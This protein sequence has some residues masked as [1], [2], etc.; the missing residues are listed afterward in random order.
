M[1]IMLAIACQKRLFRM[2]NWKTDT[3]EWILPR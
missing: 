3:F 1:W 2:Y